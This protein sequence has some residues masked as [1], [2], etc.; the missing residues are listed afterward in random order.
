MQI[1]NPLIRTLERTVRQA[2]EDPVV[3]KEYEEWLRE[4]EKQQNTRQ[5]V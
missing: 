1:P 3:K 5:Q 4:R 2:F